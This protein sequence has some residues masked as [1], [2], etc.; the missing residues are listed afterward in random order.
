ML[1]LQVANAAASA[2]VA[3]GKTLSKP[4]PKLSKEELQKAEVCVGGEKGGG[5]GDRNLWRILG[6]GACWKLSEGEGRG[7]GR[8][9]N[10]L[11]AEETLWRNHEG[12]ASCCM[13][14]SLR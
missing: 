11:Q 14:H 13:S 4:T 5:G 3:A 6:G 1:L 2:A 8:L 12:V 7:R 10:S 9:E